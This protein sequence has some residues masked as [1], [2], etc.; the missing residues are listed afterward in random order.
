MERI[1]GY[2]TAKALMQKGCIVRSVPQF[3]GADI[4]YL[5][6]PDQSP[7]EDGSRYLRVRSDSWDKLRRE[8]HLESKDPG[9]G[10]R[11]TY[12]WAYGDKVIEPKTAAPKPEEPTLTLYTFGCNT[13]AG[14]LVTIQIPAE[15]RGFARRAA[16]KM[17][18]TC[19][20]FIDIDDGLWLN[21]EHPY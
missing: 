17:I 2:A 21:D 1:I 13:Y 15:S 12:I 19:R 3:R 18:A 9:N 16:E 4:H 20:E 10:K 7:F 5:Q 8:C 6:N 14:K 11:A